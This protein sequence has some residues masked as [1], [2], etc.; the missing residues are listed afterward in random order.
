T[1][2][3]AGAN[4]A[5]NQVISMRQKG[6]TTI[7]CMCQVI[8]TGE[9]QQA[10]TGQSYLPEW[11]VSTYLLDDFNFTLKTFGD[12][13][14]LAHTMGVTFQPKQ[15]RYDMRPSCWALRAEGDTSNCGGSGDNSFGIN[16]VEEQYHS[17]LLLMAG[18]QMAGP[19]L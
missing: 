4:D 14:Q 2:G 11:V 1:G 3:N 7:I 12:P 5:L 10:A 16:V 18:I 15:V 6:V 8:Y 13:R 17:L 19:H 9:A